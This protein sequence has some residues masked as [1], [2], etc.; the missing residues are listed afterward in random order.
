MIVADFLVAG[1]KS[2]RTGL[3]P[4]AVTVTCP[5]LVSYFYWSVSP[6]KAVPPAGIKHSKHEPVGNISDSNSNTEYPP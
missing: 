3:E 5:H 2:E 6:P 4:R 1:Q